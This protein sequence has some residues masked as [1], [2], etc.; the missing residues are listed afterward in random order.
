MISSFNFQMVNSFPTCLLSIN[1]TVLEETNK[2]E[3]AQRLKQRTEIKG[4]PLVENVAV[5]ETRKQRRRDF[6][7]LGPTAVRDRSSFVSDLSVQ[8]SVTLSSGN[9]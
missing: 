8:W 2:Q 4:S 7:L 3:R 9:D 6:C 5:I 1:S